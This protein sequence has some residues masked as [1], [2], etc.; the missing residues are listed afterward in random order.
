MSDICARSI[1]LR[2]PQIQVL[3]LAFVE[4]VTDTG[5]ETILKYCSSLNYLDIYEMKNITGSSFSCIPQYAHNLQI[6]II[7]EFCEIEKEENLNVLKRLNSKLHIHRVSTW[8]F[9]EVYMC[10]LLH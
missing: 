6:L 2:C 9:G 1:I 3:S 10:G 4:T 7:E 8:K 5:I